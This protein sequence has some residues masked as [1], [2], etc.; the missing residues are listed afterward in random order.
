[1]VSP[2][3]VGLVGGLL[4]VVW[5]RWMSLGWIGR[6]ASLAITLYAAGWVLGNLGIHSAARSLG[7]AAIFI[8]GALLT[9]LFIRLIW[10]DA[11]AHH[12]R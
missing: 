11:T 10:R 6:L 5:W 7:E 9:A 2:R 3:V 1:M 8:F 4:Q 12:R